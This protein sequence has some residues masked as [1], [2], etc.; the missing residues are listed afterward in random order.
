MPHKHG[1]LMPTSLKTKPRHTNVLPAPP[2]CSASVSRNKD[3]SCPPSIHQS[4]PRVATSKNDFDRRQGREVQQLLTATDH[5]SATRLHTVRRRGIR[6]KLPGLQQKAGQPIL[7]LGPREQQHHHL[8]SATFS[9]HTILPSR[10]R[11]GTDTA[12]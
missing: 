3:A 4:H 11:K 2:E 1:P 8:P 7:W 12:Q 9:H 6:R 5:E 10:Q